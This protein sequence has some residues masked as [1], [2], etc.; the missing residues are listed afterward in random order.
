MCIVT[1]QNARVMAKRLD[2]AEL[3]AQLVDRVF[4]LP[5]MGDVAFSVD[6]F[7]SKSVLKISSHLF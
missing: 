3:V 4:D 1:A 6:D 7:P 5:K 2:A